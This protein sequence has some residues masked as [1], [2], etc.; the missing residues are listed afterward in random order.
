MKKYIFIITTTK[1]KKNADIISRKIVEEK[2]SPCVQQISGINSLFLWKNKLQ[3]EEE[4][5]LIIKA[6]SLRVMKIKEIINDF[7]E[8][9]VPE[10]I[11]Y[12]FNIL[13]ENYE[14][15]FNEI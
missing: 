6:K 14:K 10:I 3:N 15:W 4:R 5:M 11:T 1:T 7:H 9:E 2:L 8:Y 12:D 13:N